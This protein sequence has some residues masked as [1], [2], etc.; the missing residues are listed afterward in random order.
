MVDQISI[1]HHKLNTDMQR[2][3]LR[4]NRGTVQYMCYAQMGYLF[5]GSFHDEVKISRVFFG[6][7]V[8]SGAPLLARMNG[9]LGELG[10][11]R[12]E[13]FLLKLPFCIGITDESM[14][15]PPRLAGQPHGRCAWD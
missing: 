11:V 5:H 12:K 3:H 14:F 2:S 15:P 10:E 9:A 6:V 7:F 13:S 8:R 4:G 1:T